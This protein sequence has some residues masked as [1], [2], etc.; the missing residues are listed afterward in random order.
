MNKKFNIDDMK[1]LIERYMDGETTIEEQDLLS[2]FFRS[3]DVPDELKPYQRMFEMLETPMAE[4]TDEEVDAFALANGVDVRK[5][6]RL[7]PLLLKI[8][9][10]AAVIAIVFITGYRI[11]GS[12]LSEVSVLP[13][14]PVSSGRYDARTATVKGQITGQAGIVHDTVMVVRPVVIRKTIVRQMAAASPIQKDESE[15]TF[16][17]IAM[18]HQDSSEAHAR[19][20]SSMVA[21]E[22]DDVDKYFKEALEAHQEIEKKEIKN[23]FKSYGYEVSF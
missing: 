17:G 20:Y 11:G 5:K 10:V 7:L 22:P 9:S 8:A 21:T 15:T 3:S 13:R 23:D 2:G 6:A 18:A 12:R 16:H 14:T 4:P 19:Q 1:R